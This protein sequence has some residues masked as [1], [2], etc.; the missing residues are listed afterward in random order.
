MAAA[1]SRQHMV[2]GHHQQ[3]CYTQS[4][5]SSATRRTEHA[6][7]AASTARVRG[8]HD[9]RATQPH[10]AASLHPSRTRVD[11]EWGPGS[12]QSLRITEIALTHCHPSEAVAAHRGTEQRCGAQVDGD[13]H[14]KACGHRPDTQSAFPATPRHRNSALRSTDAVCESNASLQPSDRM[15]TLTS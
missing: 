6:K 13:G 7:L 9:D 8:Q 15:A 1:R 12:A 10:P 2:H 4:L 3:L 5:H 11:P 14:D